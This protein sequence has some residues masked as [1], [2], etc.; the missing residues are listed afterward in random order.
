MN[1]FGKWF[2]TLMSAVT[3]AEADCPDDAR[4]EMEGQTVLLVLTGREG[5]SR[6]FKYALNSS[7]RV[8]AALEIL[9]FRQEAD[10]GEIDREAARLSG[11]VNAKVNL[12]SRSGCTGRQVVDYIRKR[13]DVLY[14]VADSRHIL[15]AGCTEDGTPK[16][17]WKKLK[18]PLV[19][20]SEPGG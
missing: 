13:K 3:F 9:L 19:L 18:C 11:V 16:G 1:N 6:S 7:R 12:L 4:K 17:L 20:V 8:G 10:K 5:D 14:V 2:E 15:N